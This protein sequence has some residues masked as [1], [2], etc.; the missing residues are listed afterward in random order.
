MRRSIP[1]LVL[2]LLLALLPAHTAPA[3]DASCADSYVPAFEI[4]AEARR[5]TYRLGQTAVID[6]RVTDRFTGRPQS[7]TWAGLMMDGRRDKILFGYDKTDDE[8]RAVVRIR[9]KRTALE[10]GWAR[11][12]AA[13]WEPVNSPAYCTGRYGERSY[14]RLFRIRR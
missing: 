11:A 7:N 13:A 14:R 10:P 2:G 5:D 8:G 6:L 4:T 12:H 1:A 3:R 9:L